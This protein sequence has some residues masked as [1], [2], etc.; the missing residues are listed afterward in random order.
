[1]I[2]FHGYSDHVDRYYGLFPT[3]AE[4]G[5]AVF[6]VDQRGWGRSVTKPAERGLTG[7]TT[8]VLADMAAFIKSHLPASPSD[9]PVFVFGHTMGGGQ[10]LT[11][12][13]DPAYQDSLVRHVRGWLLE[14]PFIG[15]APENTPGTFK[16]L[17]GRLVSRLLPHQQLL[18]RLPP[19]TLSRDP[20]VVKSLAE[21]TLM[22]NMGT[23]EGLAGML[24]RVTN[25]SSG[26]VRPKGNALRSL[27]IGHG[28]QDKAVSF[29]IC[30]EYFDKYT[31]A[32]KDK[33]FK[34]YVGWYHQLHAEGAISVEFYNDVADWIL[35]RCDGVTATATA[36]ATAAAPAEGESAKADSKL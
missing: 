23:L 21:D 33:Q 18:N 19:E 4:R 15:F 35:A 31:D 27:W 1:M 22:H 8:R 3:L 36:T 14:S 26:T 5:I 9:P 17:A 34:V 10:A 13:C 7:P 16:L 30:K 20:D 11:L 6:G 12:A 29:P 25:L 32:V 28:T 24:D 2:H